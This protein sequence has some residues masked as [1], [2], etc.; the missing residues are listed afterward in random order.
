[1]KK[2]VFALLLAASPVA[3]QEEPVAEHG[4]V[5]VNWVSFGL[6]CATFAI[7]AVGLVLVAKKPLRTFFADRHTQLKKAV[8]EAQ[9]AKHAAEAKF[10]EYQK[11]MS[12]LD[13]EL[14]K[15][16]GTMKVN[17]EAERSRLVG[18]AEAA[19]KRIERDTETMIAQELGRAREQLRAEA[20][21][22]AV[23]MAEEILH[24]EMKP[25][26]Q[27]KLVADYTASLSHDGDEAEAA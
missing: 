25:E 14:E 19:K 9:A 22:L 27:K 10:A 4:D 11:K 26:D 2:L 13:S 15:L 3:A 1:M 21:E 20:A 16:R 6:Q 18:E 17:A 7:F 23:K 24:R 5:T 8:E 12:E